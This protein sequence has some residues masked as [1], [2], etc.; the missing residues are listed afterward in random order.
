MHFITGATHSLDYG[1]LLSL[2]IDTDRIL[3]KI[4]VDMHIQFDGFG[5]VG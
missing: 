4:N 3:C 5:L 2:L 1:K